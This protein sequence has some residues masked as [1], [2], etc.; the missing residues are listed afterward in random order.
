MRRRRSWSSTGS[1]G[2][3]PTRRCRSWPGAASPRRRRSR[4]SGGTSELA[5]SAA[6]PTRSSSSSWRR[7]C[8]R[9]SWRRIRRYRQ[10]SAQRR[11]DVT[12]TVD[13]TRTETT[14]GE[15][16][17]GAS[18]GAIKHHY[19]VGNDFWTLW[20]DPRMAYSCAMYA[21]GDDLETAQLRKLDYHIDSA[22]AA[23][24]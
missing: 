11:H 4:R 13:L 24:A 3:P 16:Y 9:A 22:R 10:S 2:G 20:L 23:G 7:A 21:N 5:G 17:A 15:P 6:G 18:Q 14:D 19:D 12:E 8:G 1:R